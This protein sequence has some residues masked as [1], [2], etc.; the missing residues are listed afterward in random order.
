LTDGKVNFHWDDNSA[1][2]AGK[3][4]DKTILL[5]YN[6][7]NHEVSSSIDQFTRSSAEG[8]V[9]TPNGTAGDKLVLYLFFQS[10]SDPTFV[11]L[12]QYL[13]SVDMI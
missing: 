4:T 13:G 11:S 7:A 6:A 3:P 9:P 2:I 5:V 12:S 8:T 10:I 1:N